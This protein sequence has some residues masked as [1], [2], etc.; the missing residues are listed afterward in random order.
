[1]P[2]GRPKKYTKKLLKEIESKINAYTESTPLPVL[3]ECAYE[4]GMHRQQLYEFP[5]LNDAIKRL[6]TKKEAVLEKGGLSGKLNASMAI[7]SLKQLGW[8]DRPKVELVE[9][10]NQEFNEALTVS[11]AALWEEE[12]KKTEEDENE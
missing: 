5:E 1:M 12:L 4:L 3:A 6:I 2:A 9:E 10:S 11:A 8:S 7:F